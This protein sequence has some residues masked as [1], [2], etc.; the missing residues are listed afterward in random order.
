MVTLQV[1][2][3]NRAKASVVNA[4]LAE[5]PEQART[6]YEKALQFGKS[7]D[8]EKAIE[9][10]SPALSF[11]EISPGVERV[12]RTVSDRRPGEQSG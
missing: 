9:N 5:V 6:L 11:P 8:S 7:G 4:A 1:K 12:G 2:A 3:S 10:L